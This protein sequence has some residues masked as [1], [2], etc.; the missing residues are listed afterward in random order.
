MR[1]VGEYNYEELAERALRF[2]AT[3]EDI[4]ALAEWFERYG[5]RYWNGERYE[6]D[7]TRSL[8]PIYEETAPDEW[9][10]VGYEIRP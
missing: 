1:Y 8:Y 4:N 10:I 3:Q 9:E 5:D 7:A 2:D 6:I